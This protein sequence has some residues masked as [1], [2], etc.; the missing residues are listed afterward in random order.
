MEQGATI[1]EGNPIGIVSVASGRLHF[2]G[3]AGTWPK[4]KCKWTESKMPRNARLEFAGIPQLILQR[5]PDGL[6]MFRRPDDYAC[7]LQDLQ[8]SANRYGCAVHAFALLPLEVAL[9][10]TGPRLGAVSRMMQMLGRRFA[11]Y[12]NKRDRTRGARW[13]GRYRSC[14]VG[15]HA[16]VLRAQT[17]VE[18]SPVRA[19]LVSD[20]CSYRW[21]SCA[22]NSV[23]TPSSWIVAHDAYVALADRPGMRCARY[24]KVAQEC[25]ID[26]ELRMHVEQGRAW[27]SDAFLREVARRRGRS[28]QARPQG[29]PRTRN[30]AVRMWTTLSPFILTIL[31]NG[32]QNPPPGT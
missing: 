22:A 4:N 17:Y 15:G 12:A 18:L 26:D 31:F 29:R 21:S 10:V 30:L 7:F 27:G 32:T 14:P 5:S 24:R 13:S 11:A 20:P 2:P 19:G 3:A 25:G 16:H 1:R 6:P 23:G 8:D 9:L 28:I